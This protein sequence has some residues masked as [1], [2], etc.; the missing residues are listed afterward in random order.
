MCGHAEPCMRVHVASGL[1]GIR[2]AR[3]TC[4]CVCVCLCVCVCMYVCV[5]VCVCVTLTPGRELASIKSY[6][7]SDTL[8]RSEGG[9]KS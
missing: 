2:H 8:K 5:C 7:E 9:I 4:V 3:R 1:T 6:T